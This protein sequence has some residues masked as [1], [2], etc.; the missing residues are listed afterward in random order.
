MA[1]LEKERTEKNIGSSLQAAPVI[2]ATQEY[3]DALHGI[4]LADVCITSSATVYPSTLKTT[5]L[6]TKGTGPLPSQGIPSMFTYSDRIPCEGRGPE[7]F[8]NSSGLVLEGVTHIPE[9]AYTLPEVAGVGVI[10]S[11]ATGDKCARCWKVTE[12]V[13]QQKNH[14]SLCKRCAEV[15]A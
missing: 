15:V 13:G 6:K 3:A 8:R 11:L 5:T 9:N 1:A 2:Y 4:D 7:S 12:E 10:A 14:P